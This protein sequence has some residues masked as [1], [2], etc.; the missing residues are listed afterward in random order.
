MTKLKQKLKARAIYNSA[1]C[2]CH[3][4]DEFTPLMQLVNVGYKYIDKSKTT[5]ERLSFGVRL[6]KALSQFT[7]RFVPHMKEEEEIFQPLLMEHFSRDELI[8][9]KNNVIKMHLQKRKV[10]MAK[11]T[12][13]IDNIGQM[14]NSQLPEADD[15]MESGINAQLPNEI[16]LKIF[17][18]LKLQDK[19]RAAQVCRKWNELV[20][21]P[22]NWQCLEYKSWTSTNQS[23]PDSVDSLNSYED[24]DGNDEY[25]NDNEEQTNS[26][27]RDKHVINYWIRSLLPRVG[28][29]VRTL[30][31]SRCKS[32]DNN[33]VRRIL[34][35]CPNLTSLDISYTRLGDNSFRNI[36]LDYLEHFNCEGCEN[37][38][39]NAFK[40]ILIATIAASLL[41]Q[42]VEDEHE[43]EET[44]E[45]EYYCGDCTS[46]HSIE[47][48][49]MMN[50]KRQAS[51]PNG[52]KYINLSG[53]W[54]I[55]DFGLK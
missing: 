16:L 6:R 54:S 1:V 55:T 4:E 21:S 19:L 48:I 43:H 26:S 44:A 47:E 18:N 39:D 28:I 42:A 38:S 46:K 51:K 37:I 31:L 29:Y 52:L 45:V 8:E 9:M 33:L 10:H 7:K 24:D 20:Y 25:D 22:S 12:S 40:F 15:E 5:S 50:R 41:Q 35:L 13:L 30:D 49:H 32:L 11:V 3:K 2:N 34:R 53:C 14:R 36:R 23:L 27:A 17:S